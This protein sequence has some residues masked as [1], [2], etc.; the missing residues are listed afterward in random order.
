MINKE[1]YLM[2]LNKKSVNL[3]ANNDNIQP[4]NCKIVTNPD[5][6]EKWETEHPEQPIGILP[7]PPYYDFVYDLVAD[8]T[9][10]KNPIYYRY[11][12]VIY[13]YTNVATLITVHIG[14]P[15]ETERRPYILMQEK[16]HH[17][18]QKFTHGIPR[19]FAKSGEQPLD[20]AIRIAQTAISTIDPNA[21]DS[22]NFA[23]LG[24][25]TIDSGLT[26][27]VVKLYNVQIHAKAEFER[28]VRVAFG[29]NP[30]LS[31]YTPDELR[32][33]IAISTITDSFTIAAAYHEIPPVAKTSDYTQS[34]IKS[35]ESNT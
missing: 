11:G 21:I 10:P 17:P 7:N 32:K 34:V 22:V 8:M 24:N 27:S 4:M 15:D 2:A 26:N 1:L 33:A 31:L 12:R 9:E 3:D 30:N 35:S 14:T 25:L 6:I 13:T 23:Y 19:G 18:A 29:E 20:T 5:I 16:Y 28:H